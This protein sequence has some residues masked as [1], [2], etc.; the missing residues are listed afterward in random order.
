MLPCTAVLRDLLVLIHLI[1]TTIKQML[2]YYHS[3]FTDE[4]TKAQKLRNVLQVTT[5]GSGRARIWARFS[6]CKLALVWLHWSPHRT[7]LQVLL[8]PRSPER[9]WT[10][11]LGELSRG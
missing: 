3:Y 6:F 11:E 2:N 1:L 8:C 7:H 10:L 4:G 9:G 5:L